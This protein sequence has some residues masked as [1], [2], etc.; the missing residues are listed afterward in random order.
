M[1]HSNNSTTDKK[2]KTVYDSLIIV[3]MYICICMWRECYFQMLQSPYS[4]NN[5]SGLYIYNAQESLR[6]QTAYVK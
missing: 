4:F 6:L 1:T 2:E 3:Y 5:F